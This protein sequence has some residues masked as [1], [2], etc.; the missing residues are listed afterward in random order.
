M[1]HLL[2]TTA[3]TALIAV[4]ATASFAGNTGSPAQSVDADP[5]EYVAKKKVDA[6]GDAVNEATG[7]PAQSVDTDEDE[8]VAMDDA[9][10][11][12]TIADELPTNSP[13]V[14]DS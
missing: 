3:A 4:M 6:D 14:S 8:E 1:T 13:A 11:N 9:D 7:S 5:D 10:G 2:K 12:G